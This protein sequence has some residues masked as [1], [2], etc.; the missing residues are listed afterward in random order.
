[1]TKTLILMRHAKS[2][3][4]TPA[5]DDHAR[6]LNAR[7][8][9]SAAALGAWLRKQGLQPDAALVSD[10][11]RTRETFSGLLMDLAPRFERMLYHAD[12]DTMLGKLRG[13]DG[14]RVLMIGH[15][16]GI[17]DFAHRILARPVTHPRFLD[18]PTG[19]TLVADFALKDWSALVWR[20]GRARD[21][22]VP[23]ELV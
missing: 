16:P 1:V 12:P 10:S 3:W 17:A 14:E 18:Y 21:F 19:A 4:D 15:N 6:P 9:R 20:S 8:R 23:R 11:Q 22:V 2:S 5:L 7:G 13:A